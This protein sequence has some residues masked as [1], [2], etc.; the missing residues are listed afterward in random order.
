MTSGVKY[1]ELDT[2]AEKQ[3]DQEAKGQGV[4]ETENQEPYWVT[5]G[6]KYTRAKMAKMTKSTSMRT[7]ST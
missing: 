1:S 7:S 3:D 2:V 6:A 5:S 4:Q